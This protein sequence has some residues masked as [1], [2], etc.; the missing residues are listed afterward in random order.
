MIIMGEQK[1]Q[2]KQSLEAYINGVK[3]TLRARGKLL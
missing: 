2:M 3:E 1:R